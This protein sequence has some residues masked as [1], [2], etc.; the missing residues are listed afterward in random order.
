MREEFLSTGL[1][2]GDLTDGD[3]VATMNRQICRFA[4][5]TVFAKRP[6]QESLIYQCADVSPVLETRAF[7]TEDGEFLLHQFAF[8]KR[9]RK[10]KWAD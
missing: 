5:N 6:G 9:K 2:H 8:G 1:A 4:Y 7:P 10:P 3:T